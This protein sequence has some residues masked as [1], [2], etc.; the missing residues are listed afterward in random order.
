MLDFGRQSS[1]FVL[2]DIR[3]NWQELLLLT[4]LTLL[5]TPLRDSILIPAIENG[6]IVSLI[7]AGLM[8]YTYRKS[9]RSFGRN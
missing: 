1:Y 2:M 4:I 3:K 7:L 6:V 8:I 9:V 5:L